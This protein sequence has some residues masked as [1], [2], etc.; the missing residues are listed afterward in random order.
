MRY[1]EIY[2]F[3]WC[4]RKNKIY[5]RLDYWFVVE[6]LANVVKQTKFLPSI[7]SDNNTIGMSLTNLTSMTHGPGY[8]KLNIGLLRDTNYI[9]LIKG[10]ISK[11]GTDM[12]KSETVE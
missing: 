8:W 6:H 10:V 5:F 3:T 11:S 1:L 7:R 12:E 2:I 9:N 4:I